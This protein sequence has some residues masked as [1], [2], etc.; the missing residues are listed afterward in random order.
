MV[1]CHLG[2]LQEV[3]SGLKAMEVVELVALAY[4]DGPQVQIPATLVYTDPDGSKWLKVRP[5]HPS[6]CK[7][8]LGHLEQYQTVKNPSLAQSPQVKKLQEKIKEAI[9]AKALEDEKAGIFEEGQEGNTEEKAAKVSEHKGR[10]R[11]QLLQQAPASVE[12]DLNGKKV[13]LKTPSSWKETDITV[14][15]Q[16]GPLTVVTEYFL[17]DVEACFTQGKKRSYNRTGLHSKKAKV[18]ES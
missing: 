10:Q 2:S 14:P 12:V 13:E 17:E 15:L 11:Q 6:I 9:L 3:A 5:S 7:V 8:M 4:K 18:D 16:P 1:P